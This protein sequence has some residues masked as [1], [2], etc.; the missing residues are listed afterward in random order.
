[1][2]ISDIIKDASLASGR[3]ANRGFLKTMELENEKQREFRH[4]GATSARRYIP[5]GHANVKPLRRWS[6]CFRMERVSADVQ[7]P[8]LHLKPGEKN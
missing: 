6:S 1:M 8:F 3:H 2:G 7:C 5:D 4:Q